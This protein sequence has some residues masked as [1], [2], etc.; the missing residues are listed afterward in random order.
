MCQHFYNTEAGDNYWDGGQYIFVD[1]DIV[2]GLKYITLQLN[3]L[4]ECI[5]NHNEATLN[6]RLGIFGLFFSFH[7]T[8]TCHL[9]NQTKRAPIDEDI[10][11]TQSAMYN[12]S[13]KQT[14]HC[15]KK[16]KTN[17]TFINMPILIEHGC[18]A[19]L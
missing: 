4:T 13:V 7:G 9:G 1:Y 2:L 19:L 16:Y 8:K 14:C 11:S 10:P 15:F 12:L 18:S 17:P 6:Y 5:S 3:L